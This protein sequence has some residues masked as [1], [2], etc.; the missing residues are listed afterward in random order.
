MSQVNPDSDAGIYARLKR[1]RDDYIIDK[2][3]APL[4]RGQPVGSNFS[5]A[6]DFVQS[7][8]Y[9]AV[10]RANSS[11][12]G[13][14]AVIPVNNLV[15]GEREQHH[16]ILLTSENG[17]HISTVVRLSQFQA[18]NIECIRRDDFSDEMIN[19]L[20]SARTHEA[21]N[22]RVVESSNVSAI[23]D[24]QSIFDEFDPLSLTEI[25]Q[26]DE[27]LW[28]EA[29]NEAAWS[30]DHGNDGM[31]KIYI[32]IEE[33]AMP[34]EHSGDNNPYRNI[35]LDITNNCVTNGWNVK[36]VTGR[37]DTELEDTVLQATHIRV[38]TESDVPL[39]NESDD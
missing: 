34:S 8:M 19:A 25:Q 30:Y 24:A 1:T 4:D 2:S 17:E 38:V 20:E 6:E 23:E 16:G 12:G 10:A 33:F 32:P 28:V 37:D 31:Q 27:P 14:S 26:S 9:W 22:I 36:E 35:P 15:F 29:T 18:T 39:D 11:F 3:A 13:L 21:S 5:N 7:H